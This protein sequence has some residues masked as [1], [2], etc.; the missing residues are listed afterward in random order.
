MPEI[1]APTLVVPAGH[2]VDYPDQNDEVNDFRIMPDGRYW[3]WPKS[4]TRP[5]KIYTGFN[6]DTGS[7]GCAGRKIEFPLFDGTSVTLHG[8][9]NSNCDAL[10]QQT[11]IDLRE[12]HLTWGC[13]SLK[14][15]QDNWPYGEI[16]FEDLLY[17]DPPEGVVGCFDRIE[18]KAKQF[19]NELGCRV[20]EYRCSSGGSS[21]GPVAPSKELFPHG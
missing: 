6:F 13:I 12:V 18:I 3:V 14:S 5:D 10:F 20:Q 16:H 11:G 15:K 4:Q 7:D 1:V 2:R 21:M 19:A 17:I 9:W 8:P